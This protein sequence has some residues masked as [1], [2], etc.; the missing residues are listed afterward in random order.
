MVIVPIMATV[1]YMYWTGDCRL[2]SGAA[3]GLRWRQQ[4]RVVALLWGRA[5]LGALT[6]AYP[7]TPP[8]LSWGCFVEVRREPMCLMRSTSDRVTW[9]SDIASIGD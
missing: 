7:R 5:C 8:F 9:P 6:L 1:P 2:V 4:A 3:T